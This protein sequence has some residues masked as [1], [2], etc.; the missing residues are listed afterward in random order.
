[1]AAPADPLRTLGWNRTAPHQTLTWPIPAVWLL[2]VFSRIRL[3]WLLW[4]L[5][6]ISG[7]CSRRGKAVGQSR[8]FQR[9]HSTGAGTTRAATPG[10][11]TGTGRGFTSPWECPISPP[12]HLAHPCHATPAGRAPLPSRLYLWRIHSN[13]IT[14]IFSIN[15][16]WR[17][18]DKGNLHMTVW[19]I[20]AQSTCLPWRPGRIEQRSPI[21]RRR[22]GR[23]GVTSPPLQ[24]INTGDKRHD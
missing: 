12:Q 3:L 21:D 11:G 1:M 2:G 14:I 17:W 10:A 18:A 23:P 24:I 19:Q 7:L 8:A 13:L 9:Q 5:Q 4:T 6:S 22:R 15:C 20:S 16:C